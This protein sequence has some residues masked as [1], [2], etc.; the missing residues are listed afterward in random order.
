MVGIANEVSLHG[1][2]SVQVVV[3]LVGGIELRC[4][5][6]RFTGWGSASKLV[7]GGI[8]ASNSSMHS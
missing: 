6:F 4:G 3:L 8:V 1:L 7:S 2:E 5:Y